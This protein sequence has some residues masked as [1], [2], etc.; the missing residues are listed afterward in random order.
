MNSTEPIPVTVAR[1]WLAEFD[2]ADR[3]GW[4]RETYADAAHRLA[5]GLRDTLAAYDDLTGGAS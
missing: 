3:A 2:R 5:R 4:D 1:D